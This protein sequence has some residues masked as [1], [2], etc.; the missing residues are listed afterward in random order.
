MFSLARMM[1]VVDLETSG[2]DP[3]VHG[4][5]SIGAVEFENPENMF[6]GECGLR[7]G[8]L[9][10][11]D[12]LKVNGFTK[13]QIRNCE[14]SCEGL[15]GEFLSWARAVKERTLAGQNLGSFDVPFLRK[16]CALFNMPWIFGY[17]YVDSHSLAFGYFKRMKLGIPMRDDRSDLSLGFLIRHFG[18]KERG[19]HN[20]LEDAKLT[21]E[22][23]RKVLV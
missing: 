6:Y 9:I 20:A 7:E 1:I 8:A 23:I 5:L 11:E 19:F 4:M 14:K 3:E 18:L 16:N 17:R 21:A 2:L 10:S 13:E 15:L 22:I 12:A